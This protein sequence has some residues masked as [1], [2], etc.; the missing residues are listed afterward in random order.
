MEITVIR[1]LPTHWNKQKKL[2]GRRDIRIL[3]VTESIQKEINENQQLLKALSPFDLI[4]ASTLARTHET[5]QLYGY[6]A[7]ADSL[8][9]ELDFG[10]FEGRSKDQLIEHYGQ[11]WIENPKELKLGESIAQLENRIILFLEKYK[12]YNHILIFG[13]GSWIRALLSY[14]RYGD[15]NHMNKI[16]VNN[17]QCI[18]LRI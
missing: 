11:Q 5:A 2:Q 1:H 15:I 3:P 10:P 8:L 6:A 13:H 17:N 16:I 18:T 4:L 14:C 7:E 12:R 9:D